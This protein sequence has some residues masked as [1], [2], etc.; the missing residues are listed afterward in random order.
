MR[1]DYKK[2]ITEYI[3]EQNYDAIV[4]IGQENNAKALRFVQMNIWGDYRKELR[5]YALS[6]LEQLAKEFPKKVIDA[7]VLLTHQKDEDYFEYVRKIKANP[8]A[9]KVKLADLNHN[10]DQSRCVG[11]DL[12][13]E[14][15]AYW[16]AK[17]SKAREILEEK[18]KEME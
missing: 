17:Y 10:A 13:Q 2:L 12:S 9:L 6:A 8:I 5:W 3:A 14:Q 4:E 1:T 15:L 18:Q 16:K 11:S 7:L